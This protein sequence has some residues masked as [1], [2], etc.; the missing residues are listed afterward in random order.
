MINSAQS[1][2]DLEKAEADKQVND[3]LSDV[4]GGTIET[5]KKQLIEKQTNCFSMI[6]GLLLVVAIVLIVVVIVC[7]V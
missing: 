4:L 3:F 5:E 6:L 7:V 2:D 1:P